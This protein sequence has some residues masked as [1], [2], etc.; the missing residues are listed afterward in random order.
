MAIGSDGDILVKFGGSV[1][2]QAENVANLNTI[3]R[4]VSHRNGR[5]RLVPDRLPGAGGYGRK[6][7]NQKMLCPDHASTVAYCARAGNRD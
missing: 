6:Q 3:G 5:R 7:C 2:A 4:I 1:E